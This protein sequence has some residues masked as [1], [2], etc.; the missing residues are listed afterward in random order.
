MICPHCK[1]EVS[2]HQPR[3]QLLDKTFHALCM[4]EHLKKA[5]QQVA[6][7]ETEEVINQLYSKTTN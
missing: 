3:I 1:K 7:K 5:H 6:E 2:P 4:I